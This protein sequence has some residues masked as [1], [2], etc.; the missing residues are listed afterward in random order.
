MIEIK[1]Q[2]E[3]VLFKFN[4]DYERCIFLFLLFNIEL[5]FALNVEFP[6]RVFLFSNLNY[7]EVNNT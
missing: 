2:F 4:N 6:G 5:E 3:S 7:Q 1:N